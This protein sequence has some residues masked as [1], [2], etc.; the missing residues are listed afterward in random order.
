VQR[1]ERGVRYLPIAI[2]S[3]ETRVLKR[4]DDCIM[5]TEKGYKKEAGVSSK[6]FPKWM[7]KYLSCQIYFDRGR[8]SSDKAMAKKTM[9]SCTTHSL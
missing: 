4:K 1:N 2:G 6:P 5:A 3:S 8:N 7:K 9:M